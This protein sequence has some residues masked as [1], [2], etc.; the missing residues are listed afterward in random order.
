MLC[1]CA[2]T[3]SKTYKVK[4]QLFIVPKDIH[5][6]LNTVSDAHFILC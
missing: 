2:L 6:C 1:R 5:E 4:E 3:A